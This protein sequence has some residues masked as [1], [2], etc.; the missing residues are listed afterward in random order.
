MNIQLSA[1]LYN[2][3]KSGTLLYFLFLEYLRGKHAADKMSQQLVDCIKHLSGRSPCQSSETAAITVRDAVDY[4]PQSCV[5]SARY[6]K[7]S[8][9][10]VAAAWAISID[11]GIDVLVHFDHGAFDS[12]EV[13]TKRDGVSAVGAVIERFVTMAKDAKDPKAV[14]VLGSVKVGS[15]TA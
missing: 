14:M 12:V 5:V 4:A 9:T 10:V 6:Q 7:K 8:G 2:K 11:E 15:V 1:P 13:H 3:D